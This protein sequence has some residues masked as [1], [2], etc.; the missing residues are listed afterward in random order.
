MHYIKNKRNVLINIVL[1]L[2]SLVL[3][4]CV[5]EYA[6]RR[7]DIEGLSGHKIYMLECGN[8]KYAI[9]LSANVIIADKKLDFIS[10]NCYPSDA[11]GL[12]PIKIINP[13]DG[14]YLYCVTYNYK[15]RRQG[16]NPDRKRRIAL[17]GDSFVI[18]QGVKETNT[19]GYYLNEKY[20]EINF[21]NWGKKGSD[22]EAVVKSCQDIIKSVPSVEEVIYFYNL[23][24]VR[25]S[26]IVRSQYKE[27]IIDFENIQ[28]FKDENRYSPLVTVLSKSA[29]FSLVRKVWI[30]KWE[31]F[32]SIQNYRDMYL[33][34]KN[35]Q[36][37][38]S[39]MD[40]IQSIKD[41][42]AARGISFRMVI[43]PLLY[44]DML[45]RYPFESIHEVIIK[46][47]NQRGIICLDGY[48]PFK[49]YYSLKRF[50]VHPLDQHPN[51]LSNL[52]LVDYINKK[53]FITGRPE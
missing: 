49:S 11:T 6:L 5:A 4:I 52:S 33:S 19:L 37:F 23:N 18:G 51:G 24:D 15:Q 48:V 13:H 20:P 45:G 9:A 22:T 39:T 50:T 10:G 16:Y 35:R 14:K 31:S 30:I 8:S 34:E 32:L 7:V 41:A 44:K 26:K 29:L 38:I 42:L 25:M 12:L 3:S 21:Q 17:V 1:C 43:Y 40:D 2:C 46:A 27:L 28:W 53:G 47:C 36:E